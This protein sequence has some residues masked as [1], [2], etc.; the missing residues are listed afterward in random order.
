MT[1]ALRLTQ[2]EFQNGNLRYLFLP[3]HLT[4][5]WLE[6]GNVGS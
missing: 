5:V 1:K 2:T 6:T 3:V 4:V